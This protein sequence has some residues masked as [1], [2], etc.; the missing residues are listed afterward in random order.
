MGAPTAQ[1]QSSQTSQ[2][3][4]KNVSSSPSPGTGK[5]GQM[6]MSSGQPQMGQPN[7]NGNSPLRPVNANFV[8]P[9]DGVTNGNPYPNTIGSLGSVAGGN[10][11]QPES[12][13]MAKGGGSGQGNGK[14]VAGAVE[15]GGEINPLMGYDE[16]TGTNPLLNNNKAPT[17][18][19]AFY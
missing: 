11:G 4:G 3:A 2:P 17:G 19:G 18:P 6:S 14:G 9:T 5:G 13:P 1:V 10:N 15:H 8:S 7:T 16:G 12:Q